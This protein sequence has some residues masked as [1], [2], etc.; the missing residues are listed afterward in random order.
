MAPDQ[1]PAPHSPNRDRNAPGP[2][3]SYD[4]EE[5][6]IP[7]QDQR[8]FGA[9]IKRKR[10]PFVPSTTESSL[11]ASTIHIQENKA[12]ASERQVG[13]RYLAIVLGQATQQGPGTEA[14]PATLR[15]SSDEESTETAKDQAGSTPPSPPPPPPSPLCDICNLPL[16]T[17]STTHP[18]EATLPHQLSLPHSHPPSHLDRSRLGLRYLSS[19][20]WDPD[21]RLGLGASGSGIR[22]PVKGKIKNDTVGLGVETRVSGEDEDREVKKAKAGATRHKAE[23]EGE[24]NIRSSKIQGMNGR[25]KRDP[26]GNG[27]AEGKKDAKTVRRRAEASRREQDR[28]HE[29][30]YASDDVL[31]YL[32][33]P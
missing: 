29:M 11:T 6:F 28:L 2:S 33:T 26:N 9:G 21:S 23:Q 13:D 24:V 22:V 12:A 31:R 27:K 4:E 3:S 14:K 20:G 1:H 32:G 25:L 30:F 5:Y 10:V 17:P 7:L 15:T 8:V 16:T 19:Y 18:H